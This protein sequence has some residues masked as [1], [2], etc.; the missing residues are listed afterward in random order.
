MGSKKGRKLKLLSHGIE[1]E[2]EISGPETG[3]VVLMIAGLGQQLIDWPAAL[4]KAL[5]NAGYKVIC[6]DNRD[7]GYSQSFRSTGAPPMAWELLKARFG[8][9][10]NA[11]YSIADMAQDA[12]GILDAL[13]IPAAHVIGWSMGGMIAQRFAL[14]YPD[15]T[16]TLTCIMTSSG[17]PVTQMQVFQAMGV[18]QFTHTVE[19]K[20]EKTLTIYRLLMSPSYPEP[21]KDMRARVAASVERAEAAKSSESGLMRQMLAIMADGKRVYE[22]SAIKA[23]TLVIHGAADP[24]VALKGGQDIAKKIRGSKMVI[25]E[26][27][28]HD[29]PKKLIPQIAAEIMLHIK[30]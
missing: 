2:V 12:K 4:I 6:F 17:I 15:A 10:V 13:G 21:E 30:S 8:M 11:P 14:S 25:Y 16:L 22:I 23:P 20:I 26:G 3:P 27:M 1:I 9:G 24:M 18:P 7:I 5:V 28:G 19:A 29:F